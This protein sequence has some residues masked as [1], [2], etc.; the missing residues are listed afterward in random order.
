M[1]FQKKKINRLKKIS[2]SIRIE[3]IKMLQMAGSGHPGGSLSSLDILVCLYFSDFLNL[4]KKNYKSNKRDLVVLSAGHYCPTLYAILAYKGFFNKRI[5]ST[6]RKFDSP[7]LGHPKLY[8]LPGIENSGGSLGQGISLACGYAI[9]AKRFSKNKIPKVY[10]LMGDGEQNEGQ[11]WEAAMFAGHN[12]LNN[13]CA[14]VDINKIQIDGYTKDILNAEPFEKKYQSFNWNTIRVDG[15]NHIKI[16]NAFKKFLNYKGK[17][18]TVI[19]ADTVAGKGLKSIEGLV[20]SHGQPIT[21]KHLDE[22]KKI[23]KL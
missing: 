1:N 6:L 20:T 22:I 3:V 14:I 9:S 17:K 23:F 7:L 15:N 12:K 13:L 11:V 16:M 5:L 10:C 21:T 4:N 18:P 8:E 19:L 2:N